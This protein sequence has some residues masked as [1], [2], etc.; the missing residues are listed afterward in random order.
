MT[1]LLLTSNSQAQSDAVRLSDKEQQWLQENHVVRIRVGNWPPFMLADSEVAGIAVDYIEKIFSIHGIHYEFIPYKEFTWKEALVSIRNHDGVDLLPTIKQTDDRA[2]D[3]SFTSDYLTLP[4]VIFT[5]DDSSFVGDIKDLGSKTVCVPNS[6]V[7]HG[8]LEKNYPD[9]NLKV[10]S[11]D[12][13]VPRCLESLANGKVDAFIGNLAVGTY[14]IQTKGYTNL[15]VA[16]PTPFGEHK[17]AMAVRND[18]PELASIID[19]TLKEFALKDH[20]EIRN[21]WLS[22]RYEHG[23]QYTDILKWVGG[24]SFVLT[25]IILATLFHSVTLRKEILRRKEVERQLNDS[26]LKYRSLSDASFEAVSITRNGAIIETNQMM[27]VLFGYTDEDLVGMRLKDFL[28]H[29]DDSVLSDITQLSSEQP[30]E[31]IFE[32]R[33]GTP[34]YADVLVRKFQYKNENVEVVSIHDLTERK[35]AEE[36]IR[37]LKGIIPI[38]MHCKEIRDDK[39]YWNQ[40]EKYISQ[41]SEA[42]FS[43]AICETCLKKYYP[44]YD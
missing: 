5:R 44:D 10:L 2:Q 21:K 43:H 29:G 25:S 31:V 3:M 38:C 6:F 36:E 9:I 20:A 27:T 17:Q 15:K 35:K 19:K 7:M 32:K 28:R 26:E 18:W 39:G 30:S 42:E 12:N 22:V 34:F 8:L 24:V 40:M 11:G 37:T 23:I 13:V 41:H 16:A 33:D 1:T 14:L 4:W